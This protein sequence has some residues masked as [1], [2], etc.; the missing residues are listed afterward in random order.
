MHTA[1]MRGSFNKRPEYT[2]YAAKIMVIGADDR[3]HK[4][5]DVLKAS[6]ADKIKVEYYDVDQGSTT[7][8]LSNV[9]R[10]KSD[11]VILDLVGIAQLMNLE[12]LR[13]TSGYTNFVRDINKVGSVLSVVTLTPAPL[14]ST[15]PTL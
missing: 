1:S 10:S 15:D 14:S 3:S 7:A 5:V 9:Q 12:P 13:F 4:W 8:A 2:A 11:V 6:V